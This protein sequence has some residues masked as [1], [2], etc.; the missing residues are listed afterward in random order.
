MISLPFVFDRISLMV[1]PGARSLRQNPSGV[2]SSTARSVTTF[3][4]QARPVNGRLH[5]GNNLLSPFGLV[6]CM[7][8]I[9]CLAPATRS[10]APPMPF[11][12]FPG[13]FQ[14]A[15]SPL[16]LTSIGNSTIALAHL[17]ADEPGWRSRANQNKFCKESHYF[18]GW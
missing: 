1:T 6:C 10:I 13:I 7:A 17:F 15:I 8:M 16:S 3:F 11:T 9:I 2:I 4:T 14:L 18:R 5:S 12:I